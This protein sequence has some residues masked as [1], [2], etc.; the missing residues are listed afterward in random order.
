MVFVAFVSLMGGGDPHAA[1]LLA[2]WIDGTGCHITTRTDGEPSIC[3]LV[4]RARGLHADGGTAVD[5]VSP[6]GDPRS[7]RRAS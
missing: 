4:R 3:E 5:E 1:R 6:T 7:Q 2:K